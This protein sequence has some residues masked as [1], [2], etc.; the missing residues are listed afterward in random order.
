MGKGDIKTYRGKLFNHSY[1]NKRPRHGGKKGSFS[2]ARFH[3]KKNNHDKGRTGENIVQEIANG[4]YLKYW[5]FP[6]PEDE[7]GDKKELC[8]L[9]ILFD[10]TLILVEVKNYEFDSDYEKYKKKVV[11]KASNQLF[12]AQRKLL[13]SGRSIVVKH[14]ERGAFVIEKEEIQNTHRIAVSVGSSFQHYEFVNE[15]ENKGLINIW[16]KD[17]VQTIFN[18]LD[19]IPDLIDY[20]KEREKLFATAKDR[21]IEC[22]E[23][24][25]LAVFLMNERRFPESYYENDI[26]K[27]ST[28][29]KGTWEKYIKSKPAIRKKLAEQKSYFID[30]IVEKDVLPVKDGELLAMEF[31]ALSRFERTI[32]AGEISDLV[33]KY[34]GIEGVYARKYF[35]YK[36]TP[37]LFTYYPPD[38]DSKL[39]D[40]TNLD[41]CRI[42]AYRQKVGKIV[43]FSCAEE[44][45]EW[46]FGLFIAEPLTPDVI[47]ELEKKIKDFG[48]FENEQMIIKNVQEYPDA[49]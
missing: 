20:L 16:N 22:S 2:N 10:D 40:E 34:Q 25:F 47:E 38:I 21:F 30:E 39:V 1:G 28:G 32:V 19:T 8:D 27:I 44:L 13:E 26:I 18:E 7:A 35:S 9:I 37:F 43:L 46:R 41:A 17:T 4:S 11:Q 3:T 24:D 31:M 12:G 23:E 49:S 33:N 36:L 6:N 29:L 15:V 14:P 42:Y 45:K 5:C 48:W